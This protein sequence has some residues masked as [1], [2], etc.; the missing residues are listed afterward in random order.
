MRRP[1]MALLV[2]ALLLLLPAASRAQATQDKLANLLVN[3]YTANAV[4][5]YFTFASLKQTYPDLAVNESD[6]VNQVTPAYLFNERLSRQVSSMPIGSSA[7]GFTWTFSPDTGTFRRASESFGP[8]FAERALTSGRKKFN[9]GFSYQHATFDTMEDKSLTDGSI[10]V[11]ASAYLPSRRIYLFTEDSLSLKVSSNTAIIFG[12]YG[13]TDRLDIG[14]SIPIMQVKMDATLS[15]RVGTTPGTLS[16]VLY[17]T[18]SSGSASGIGDIVVRAKYNVLRAPGGGLAAGVDVRL[19]TGDEMNLLGLPGSQVKFSLIGSTMVGRFAPHV[20]LGYTASGGS[21]LSSN[22]DS[23]LLDPPNEVNFVAGFDLV[24]A[25]RATVAVDLL[26]RTQL[27]AGRLVDTAMAFSSTYHQFALQDGSLTQ[28]FAAL[29]AKVNAFSNLL[30]SANV[31]LPVQK[32]GLT[33][34]TWVLGL[35]YS[36]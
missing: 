5:N 14:V 3:L 7:G 18:P 36:F 13:A 28:T 33:G 29:G 2:A 34:T 12:T 31:L 16:N 11:Y 15:S 10:K 1:F 22:A 8:S 35:D 27:K 21:N 26:S 23:P 24:A 25:P 20:N 19:G 30:V 4:D 6:I 32:T 17:T 9:L